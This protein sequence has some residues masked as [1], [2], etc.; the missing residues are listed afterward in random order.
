[1]KKCDYYAPQISVVKVELEGMIASSDRIPISP[2]PSVPASNK[3]NN[4][5]NSNQWKE[6]IEK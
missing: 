3:Y 4:Y 1:M 2:T 5:W 6:N